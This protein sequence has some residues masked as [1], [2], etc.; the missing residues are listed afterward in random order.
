LRVRIAELEAENKKLQDLVYRAYQEGFGDAPSKRSE[1]DNSGNDMA[2]AWEESY[3]R[4]ALNGAKD[5]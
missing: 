2:E 1:H 4:A 5:V 3:A